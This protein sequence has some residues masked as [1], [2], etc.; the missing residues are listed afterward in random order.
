MLVSHTTQV[1]ATNCGW[2]PVLGRAFLG[3]FDGP[4]NLTCPSSASQGVWTWH[5]SD[6]AC[7]A[8]FTTCEQVALRAPPCPVPLSV[9]VARAGGAHRTPR[10][11][12]HRWAQRPVVGARPCP[13]W[14]RARSDAPTLA[15][16]M[17]PSASTAP[18]TRTVASGCSTRRTAFAR[19]PVPRRASPCGR[20]RVQPPAHLRPN[21]RHQLRLLPV[22]AELG[23]RDAGPCDA[24]ACD[25]APCVMMRQWVRASV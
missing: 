24:G 25:A 17:A 18:P 5:S 12:A 9:R 2:C 22:A 15:R 20:A 10:G 1:G 23:Q 14:W 19:K 13:V 3:D 8:N 4:A 11:N 21:R 6:C 7:T 16:P